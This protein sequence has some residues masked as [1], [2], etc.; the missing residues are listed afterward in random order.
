MLARLPHAHAPRFALAASITAACLF[1]ILARFNDIDC[2]TTWDVTLL[3]LLVT[4][5]SLGLVWSLYEPLAAA[6][7]ALGVR[8]PAALVA[9]PLIYLAVGV[10]G[11]ALIEIDPVGIPIWL[12]AFLTEADFFG[13]CE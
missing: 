3:L 12:L 11:W 4:G 9:A 8:A 6:A 10:A 2:Y 5:F 13:T 7:S 1:T